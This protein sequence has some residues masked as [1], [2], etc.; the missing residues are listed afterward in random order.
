MRI[1]RRV[2]TGNT[3]LFTTLFPPRLLLSVGGPDVGWAAGTHAELSA[4]SL[5]VQQ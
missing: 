5:S 3:V 1:G 2:S 4:A